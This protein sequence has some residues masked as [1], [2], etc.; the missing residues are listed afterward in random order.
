MNDEPSTWKSFTTL[1]S[2]S[3]MLLNPTSP[4][5]RQW[6]PSTLIILRTGHRQRKAYVRGISVG[7][8]N[9]VRGERSRENGPEHLGT[10]RDP[11]IQILKYSGSRCKP[12]DSS[13]G[14][15]PECFLGTVRPDG[16]LLQLVELPIQQWQTL[17]T[18]TSNSGANMTHHRCLSVTHL[19]LDG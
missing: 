7:A 19:S 14:F 12:V 18:K 16:H 3:I 10:K 9:H 5:K 8:V 2:M 15:L 1:V 6:H 4:G 13:V 11:S 17:L